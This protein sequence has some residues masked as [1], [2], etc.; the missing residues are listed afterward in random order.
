MTKKKFTYGFDIKDYTDEALRRLQFNHSWVTEEHLDKRYSFAIEKEGRKH[1]FVE[2]YRYDDGRTTREVY[3]G[4]GEGFVK[5][6]VW[7]HESYVE[8][9]NEVT[10]TFRLDLPCLEFNGWFLERYDFEKHELGGVSTNI[11]AGN[12]STGGN[13]HFFLPDSFF[14]GTYDEFI[15]KYNNLVPGCFSL[16]KEW[17]DKN[18]GLKKFLGF[19]K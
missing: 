14:E 6:I 8:W 7:C 13:R 16:E 17:L 18:K 10:E 4:D 19:K 9:N 3:E 11:Q 5:H 15:E 2:Y 1:V 12:R